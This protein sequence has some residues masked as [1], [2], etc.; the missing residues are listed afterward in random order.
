[1]E[2]LRDTAG[3]I[4]ASTRAV[5]RCPIHGDVLMN[6]CDDDGLHGAIKRKAHNEYISSAVHPGP[7]VTE[8]YRHLRNG[9]EGDIRARG[10]RGRSSYLTEHLCCVKTA[11][12][13]EVV[14]VER[15]KLLQIAAGAAAL[16]A[17][18]QSAWAQ[19]Y[20]S[21]PITIIV[22][23]HLLRRWLACM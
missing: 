7:V 13:E 19:A 20:P 1:M 18:S 23:L 16:L 3:D 8:R 21:R 15:R 22:P 2:E 4:A 11:R 12:R 9:P 10:K 14:N 6:S 17:V 5:V